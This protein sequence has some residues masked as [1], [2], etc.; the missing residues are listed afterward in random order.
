MA[1]HEALRA[2]GGQRPPNY[3][4]EIRLWIRS[5]RI[6]PVRILIR[7]LPTNMHLFN[8]TIGERHV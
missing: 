5:L 1:F 6:R 2:T 8:W 3:L 4:T 7:R